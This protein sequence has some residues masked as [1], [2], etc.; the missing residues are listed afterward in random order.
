MDAG[1]VVVGLKLDRRD[2]DNDFNKIQSFTPSLNLDLKINSNHKKDLNKIQRLSLGINLK[3]NA[4]QLKTQIKSLSGTTVNVSLRT[5]IS[6]LQR[7]LNSGLNSNL[8]LNADS[9]GLSEGITKAIEKGFNSVKPKSGIFSMLGSL[10]TAPLQG[11]LQ[12]V[13]MGVGDPVGKGINKS[14]QKQL[15]SSIGSIELF[16]EKSFSKSIQ[17]LQKIPGILEDVFDG[18]PIDVF[19]KT[20][21]RQLESLEKTLDKF[22]LTLSPQKITGKIVSK[23]EV[24]VESSAKS[25]ESNQKEF[26]S[27]K[28]AGA[29][30]RN[31]FLSI[32]DQEANAKQIDAEISKREEALQSYLTT[33][34]SLSK[35]VEQGAATTQDKAKISEAS[36]KLEQTTDEL[37]GLRKA[38][39][40]YDRRLQEQIEILNELG[41]GGDLSTEAL[42]SSELIKTLQQLKASQS[43]L[44][45]SRAGLSINANTPVAI[46]G[47]KLERMTGNVEKAQAAL[48]SELAS[49]TAT[50]ESVQ[51]LQKRLA[52][53]KKAL[54]LYQ[55][56]IADPAK[57]IKRVEK[58]LAQANSA[59]SKTLQDLTQ[60]L[61]SGLAEAI[62]SASQEAVRVSN[63]PTSLSL[64]VLTGLKS[65]YAYERL[66]AKKLFEAQ[67]AEKEQTKTFSLSQESNNLLTGNTI[68]DANKVSASNSQKSLVPSASTSKADYSIWDLSGQGYTQKIS[69]SLSLDKAIKGLQIDKIM[70]KPPKGL[71]DFQQNYGLTDDEIKVIQSYTLGPYRLINSYL[72]DSR[73]GLEAEL[74]RL[75]NASEKLGADQVKQLYGGNYDLP[76]EELESYISTLAANLQKILPKL[77]KYE[78]LAF[79]GEG[80]KED[81]DSIKQRLSGYQESGLKQPGFSS[82]GITEGFAGKVQYA[83]K[84]NSGR[85]LQIPGLDG[86][87]K[88]GEAIYNAGSNFKIL[89]QQPASADISIP[90]SFSKNAEEIKNVF[91]P[92]KLQELGAEIIIFLEEVDNIIQETS[93]AIPSLEDVWQSLKPSFEESLEKDKLSHAYIRGKNLSKKAGYKYELSKDEEAA[94]AAY[95]ATGLYGSMNSYLRGGSTALQQ[96]VNRDRIRIAEKRKNLSEEEIQ[97]RLLTDF[98]EADGLVERMI[99]YAETIS[100]ALSKLPRVDKP[101][102]F[103]GEGADRL[104]AYQEG[105]EY[106]FPGFTSVAE[107]NPFTAPTQVAVLQKNA[108]DITD[109]APLA[110]ISKEKGGA[111]FGSELLLD[112]GSRFKA[113]A[114]KELSLE[115]RQGISPIDLSE[116]QGISQEQIKAITAQYTPE[117]IKQ[118]GTE[119][120]VI[121]EELYEE[122]AQNLQKLGSETNKSIIES[123][124]KLTEIQLPELQKILSGTEI[125]DVRKFLSEN[126]NAQGVKDL[127]RR[128]SLGT[129]GATKKD[130]INEIADLSGTAQDRDDLLQKVSQMSPDK[131]LSTST[132][133]N[134]G[135]SETDAK[136]IIEQLKQARKVL[137]DAIAAAQSLQGE[138][139]VKA[140]EEIA[141]KAEQ[142]Y[143]AAKQLSKEYQ[144]PAN[145]SK[146]LGGIRSQLQEVTKQ[147]KYGLAQA[148]DIGENLSE[149]I[150][151][152]IKT[153]IE[154]PVKAIKQVMSQV[155]VAAEDQAEIKSPSRVFVRIGKYLLAGLEKGIKESQFLAVS[156]M[157]DVMKVM[158]KVE[159]DLSFDTA[160]EVLDGGIKDLQSKAENYEFKVK[161]AN[162]I[163]D[164]L[165]NQPKPLT[166]DQVDNQRQTVRERAKLSANLERKHGMTGLAPEIMPDRINAQGEKLEPAPSIIQGIKGIFKS[167]DKSIYNRLK[168]RASQLSLEVEG[169]IAP[170]LDTQA[171]AAEQRGDNDAQKQYR[172]LAKQARAAT[173]GVTR[174]LESPQITAKQAKQLERL[175]EHLEK[176]Y[177]T[178]GRP[179][180]SQGFI[181]SLGFQ[182][183]SVFKQL[184]GLIKGILAFSVT[185]WAQ[186]FFGDIAKQAFNAYVEVDRLRTSLNFSSNSKFAGGQNLKFANNTADDLGIDLKPAQ[187]G[188]ASLNAAARGTALQGQGIKELFLGMSQASTVLSMSTEQSQRAFAALTQILSKGKVSSEELRQQLAESGLVGAMG[189]AARAV[190][191]TE[192]EFNRLLESG[193]I[194]SQDFLPKFAKQLQAEFGDAA[195]DASN[196]AQS[197]IYRFENSYLSLQQTL[198][199]AITPVATAG[200]NAIA[201]AMNSLKN[202]GTELGIA[203]GVLATVLSLKMVAGLFN[204][205]K[206][207]IAA[208]FA[209]KALITTVKG[210]GTA[211][212]N[213]F[214][215]KL[216]VG[217][218]GVLEIINLLNKAVNTEL[219]RSF[220]DAAAAA[221]RAADESAKAFEKAKPETRENK[222]DQFKPRS[223]DGFGRFIDNVFI[224]PLNSTGI[225]DSAE[226]DLQGNPTGRINQLSSY[227]DA[228]QSRTKN[229]VDQM[230]Q[231]SLA[232]LSNARFRLTQLQAGVGDIGRLPKVQN[233]LT[234]AEQQR[235]ITQAQIK[236]DYTDK[237]LA[238]PAELKQ[239]LLAENAN[240][241]QLN[242]Q[243]AEIAKPFNLDITRTN[244]Q[245]ASVKAQI[246][247]LQSSDAIGVLGTGQSV[248]MQEQLKG[249]LKKLQDF[250]AKSEEAL[251]SLK[252]DPILA[253]SNALRVLNRTF[254]QAQEANQLEFN[255]KRSQITR[256]QVASFST[257]RYGN[258][259]S[260]I[261]TAIAEETKAFKDL[262][263]LQKAIA[264][265]NK[266]SAAPQF[267]STLKRLGLNKNS[268]ISQ[269]DDILRNTKDEADKNILEQFKAGRELSSR[270]SEAQIQLSEAEGKRLNA[271]QGLSLI[272]IQD[273][274]KKQELA[275]Q[276]SQ[277]NRTKAV[278]SATMQRLITESQAAEEAAKIQLQNTTTQ[279]ENLA[280]QIKNLK[281]YH[282]AGKISA[283]EY[284]KQLEDLTSQQTNLEVQAIEQ[285]LQVFEAANRRK[286]EE[287]EAANAKARATID[288]NQTNAI[289]DVRAGLL[290]GQ[291]SKEQVDRQQ[292]QVEQQ[293]I[294]DRIA[295]IKKQ[296]QQTKELETTKVISAKQSTEKQIQLNQQLAQS[297]QQLIDKQIQAQ[298]QLRA[299]INKTFSRRKAQLDL[300]N[301]K[302]DNA[303]NKEFVNNLKSGFTDLR[304]LE[305]D[306]SIKSLQN[307]SKYLKQQ[308]KIIQDQITGIDQLKLSEQEASDRRRDLYIQLENLR[309]EQISTEKDLVLKSTEQQTKAIERSSQIRIGSIEKEKALLSLYNQSLERTA[310]LEESRYNLA[311]A[312]K[313]ASLTGKEIELDRTNRAFELS[314]RLKDRSLKGRDRRNARREL[315]ALGFS[316]KSSEQILKQRAEL[317]S[318]IAFTKIDALKKEQQFQQQALAMDLKRQKVAAQMAVLEAETSK[319]QAQQELQ[320]ARAKGDRTG[321]T[322]ALNKI[323]LA[324]AKT[325]LA[326][327][328][329]ADFE[330]LA[331]NATQAQKF[332]QQAERAKLNADINNKALDTG[333]AFGGLR[334]GR[335]KM[336]KFPSLVEEQPRHISVNQLDLK[337]KQGENIF[338]SYMRQRQEMKDLSKKPQ[339]SNPTGFKGLV[340]GLKAANRGVEERLERLIA[341]FDKLGTPRS[342]T[343]TTPNPVDDA[344][345][346]MNDV[347]RIGLKGAGV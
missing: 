33:I 107:K 189:I 54:D 305:L 280:T 61:S 209:G 128:R 106:T 256:Q 50:A 39:Q 139:R 232:L 163:Q 170:S 223:S 31:E 227:G 22:N 274:A 182:A 202:I 148:L 222:K 122:T 329:L 252:V 153:T 231:D 14:L 270:R 184:G 229:A 5:D 230:Q 242:Q 286:L 29:S 36:T 80:A 118:S 59:L 275:L 272:K 176:I 42:K 191:V 309:K 137:A 85:L 71:L 328:G 310:K 312:M 330:E 72:R 197:A 331:N 57:E 159:P 100:S 160:K 40:D 239:Q 119:V 49:P 175:T 21:Q 319:L 109:Y 117:F 338:E 214:S 129:K 135:S 152:G 322:I 213:S 212:N 261:D 301:T 60:T 317:E 216:A 288:L 53:A 195:K 121:L 67:K 318:Q 1:N 334:R 323:E 217:L 26:T 130:L 258:K 234:Q 146:S 124:S 18:T 161:F 266:A 23:Q 238:V 340:E 327:Q 251:A 24:A 35:K 172:K 114:K 199:E 127:A 16:S 101:V 294:Y 105:Q 245:I 347:S 178:I 143:D 56:E 166:P 279:T 94:L 225:F 284:H 147:A 186:Q 283:E 123:L 134:K 9:I 311:K 3:A 65:P 324:D 12:G 300:E 215:A 220:E 62:A 237:G 303:I 187:E 255:N 169:A 344:A 281:A 193:Q 32:R 250:K 150:G 93:E 308:Q 206:A 76:I 177:D 51:K 297:N 145:Q 346:I 97:K 307:R 89:S 235:Q 289:T 30:A 296:I 253:F 243:R 73:K 282:N 205:V 264:S 194:L 28:K 236:R 277:A 78:G 203:V 257:D 38:R 48:D 91:S 295:N 81:I 167:L 249:I 246:E 259:K 168:K 17:G 8:K 201:E 180:P 276:K 55:I 271:N 66:A 37:E 306:S 90:E 341:N 111:S 88:R 269:I 219:V 52:N 304:G 156:A 298:E 27:R 196:N 343:V 64:P 108:R 45:E 337:P 247:A 115:E 70:M 47:K 86:F 103:R 2:F 154:E 149:A 171:I 162:D 293:A 113:I 325:G 224:N 158:A 77:P 165:E 82:F 99:V 102:L 218:F 345:K 321:E 315:K 248:E 200:L 46:R 141:S 63:F 125:T 95:T 19:A 41:V 254:A 120:I 226:L 116:L 188:F 260:A 34:N 240:I 265:F 326:L 262:Q 155:Q 110:N 144:L 342:L 314:K 211:I 157:S 228:E 335:F 179:L 174:I 6:A 208:K 69:E 268:S 96:S 198:G 210:I 292:N 44:Q 333:A 138:E 126:L 140:F 207:L 221:K 241:A 13:F 299:A 20:M 285:R 291:T 133:K 10:I 192:Q 74:K 164:E 131:F 320:T 87:E 204:A 98:P 11:A 273:A 83:I 151:L 336:P 104:E 302:A 15:G 68:S 183:S 190:G 112:R 92:E 25:F 7:Q 332:S 316:G 132:Y 290:D 267:Q 79:R 263:S 339:A 173:K 58:Q 181:E 233:Q 287:I 136:D 244:Q 185:S 84:S 4:N 43:A 142:Q 313:D 278:K 75:Q